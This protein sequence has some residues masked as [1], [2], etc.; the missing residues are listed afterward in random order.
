M[1]QR[2]LSRSIAF[3][4]IVLS[5]G[6]LRAWSPPDPPY[7]V[8]QTGPQESVTSVAISADGSLVA[9]GSFD[10]R[11]RIHD[12]RTGGLRRVIGSD[13][14]RGVR[15]VA[16]APDGTTIVSGGLE[17]DRTLKLWN[18]GT[19]ELVRT[20]AGHEAAGAIY[21]EVHAVAFA[22]GGK[23]VAS[24]GRD[25]L[26]L[27]W[28]VDTG[29][30]RLRLAA[31]HG[32]AIALAFAPG[33]GMLA[34]GG[35]DKLIRLWDLASGRLI[36]ALEGEREA[37]CALAFSPDGKTLASA[38]TDWA[39]HRGRDT[40]RFPGR[41]P[42]SR[43]EWR[44][45]DP[46][47]GT[48]KRTVTEAARVSSLAF[49]PDGRSL[50]CGAGP[51]VRLHDLRSETPGRTVTSHD[52]AVTSVAFAP[53]G[54][55]VVSGSHDRTV[56][57]VTIP[58]AEE[59]WRSPGYWEQVNSVAISPDGRFIAT[60]S[61]DIRF[62]E[63][64]LTPGARGLG[65]RAVRLWDAGTGRLVRRL[66]DPARQ[67]MA[68]A[69]SP[70]S[71]RVASA[72]A[73]ASGSG[74]IQLWDVATGEPVWSADGHAA[75]ALAVA[76]AP[77]GSSL[78]TAGANGLITL[79]DP[80][81]SSIV[82]TLEGHQSG[83][84]SV[85]FSGD[86]AIVCGGGADEGAYLW[87]VRTGRLIRTIRPTKSLWALFPRGHQR[88]ITSVAVSADGGTLVTCSGSGSPEYGDRLVRVWDT[89]SGE[90]QREFSRPQSRGRF[91]ALSPDG[92]V[93]AT[94]GVGKSIALWDVKT[95]R[96]LTELVGHPHPPQSAAFSADGRLLVSGADYR[97]A[98]VWEVPTRRL[99]AT[100]V[101]FSESRPGTA[102]D[103]WLAY[104]PDGFY[105]G[106]SDVDRY[107]VWWFG[108]ALR[109]ADTL[110]PQLHRPDRLAS[111]LKKSLPKPVS[112]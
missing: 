79:R 47:T 109:T 46:T 18:V 112:P 75:E 62:A 103:D 40:S 7:L 26:V 63:R 33:G 65:P 17:M 12:A 105:D 99:L 111:A 110:G 107:L 69:F 25:G 48:L 60:G 91:V 83:V 102:T 38:N 29:K 54:M 4:L 55:A 92:T 45:W 22:P 34:S 21:A 97:T 89:R 13:P 68:V 61:S 72:G 57:R 10:G 32:A 66:G 44:L 1:R 5:G 6:E 88:L 41:D 42:G 108:G 31:H 71:R 52:G 94:N 67:V 80:R 37:V 16:F 64:K 30:L 50:A 20:L 106:S 35:A 100:L 84:T 101:T 96:L 23:L 77:D 73:S 8:L 93:L 81:T 43:N 82:R 51:D 3:G 87:E 58:A 56:R 76:F 98:M 19:G 27:V 95:G 11:V 90:L 78:A 2:N 85:A 39:Y 15:A 104:T 59:V 86:G 24:A 49:A 70:D 28:D 14:S 36:R 9:T 74:V 53:D